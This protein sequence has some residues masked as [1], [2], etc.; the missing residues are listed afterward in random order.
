MGKVRADFFNGPTVATIMPIQLASS[1]RHPVV[2][3]G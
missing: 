1:L 3:A 2:G